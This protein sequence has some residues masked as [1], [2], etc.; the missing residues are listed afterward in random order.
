MYILLAKNHTVAEIIPDENPIFPS[1]PVTARYAPDFVAK[2]LHVPDDTM[3][4]Q[5]WVYDKETGS[6]HEPPQPEPKPE[7]VED[8]EIPPDTMEV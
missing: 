2:L 6:F 1:V 4:K 5:N 7:P 3:V 8:A